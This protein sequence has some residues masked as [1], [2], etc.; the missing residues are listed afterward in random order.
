MTTA[1]LV[2][3]FEF[4][5]AVSKLTDGMAYDQIINSDVPPGV[6]VTEACRFKK[7]R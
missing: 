7:M 2:P 3:Y 5:M 1:V 4:K 6:L